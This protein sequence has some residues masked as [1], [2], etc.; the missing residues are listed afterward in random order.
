MHRWGKMHDP[1][2]LVVDGPL[3]PMHVILQVTGGRTPQATG[4][5]TVCA[6]ARAFVASCLAIA[7]TRTPRA[8]S[9]VGLPVG[10]DDII[11]V[12]VLD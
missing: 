1:V 3:S 5:L 12:D 11:F 6:V 9:G 8:S 4:K 7:G 2:T 10:D